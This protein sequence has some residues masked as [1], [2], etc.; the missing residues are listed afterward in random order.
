MNK[1]PSAAAKLIKVSYN[2]ETPA[3]D[4]K[5][6]LPRIISLKKLVKDDA[7]ER[8]QTAAIINAAPV[9]NLNIH[10]QLK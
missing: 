1:G 6:R 4:L 3:A 8:E 5:L 9:K 10:T 7:V 2:K